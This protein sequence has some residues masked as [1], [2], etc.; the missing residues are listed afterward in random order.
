MCAREK[1]KE[2]KK[3]AEDD[4]RLFSCAVS[5]ALA[6]ELGGSKNASKV[7]V[8]REIASEMGA[9]ADVQKTGAV[10]VMCRGEVA[11]SGDNWRRRRTRGSSALAKEAPLTACEEKTIFCWTGSH[12]A[13]TPKNLSI[14]ITPE[15]MAAVMLR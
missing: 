13:H 2:K 14:N 15:A 4:M 10:E 5:K 11:T 6:S 12:V 1:S 8:G 9:V 7:V 3:T